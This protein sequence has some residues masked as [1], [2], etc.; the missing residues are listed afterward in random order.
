[1]SRLHRILEGIR[2]RDHSDLRREFVAQVAEVEE[3]NVFDDDRKEA[4]KELRQLVQ[5]E[6]QS[7]RL[8]EPA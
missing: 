5:M 4:L 8:G 2:E 1:M 6:V 3:R 7:E